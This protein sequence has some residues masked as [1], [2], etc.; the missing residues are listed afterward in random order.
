M[1]KP[2]FRAINVITKEWAYGVPIF[3]EKEPQSVYIIESRGEQVCNIET[4]GQKT[5]VNDRN[6]KEIWEGDIYT[7]TRFIN[8]KVK[9]FTGVI[10]F[11]YAQ[12]VI[13][14]FGKHPIAIEISTDGEVVGN[15]HETPD[16]ASK[17]LWRYE[18]AG[19]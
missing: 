4:L 5:G 17:S 2:L 1:R 13:M 6:G 7:C 11:K 3:K 10:T 12:F 15:I 18:R 19:N 8:Q 14:G 16:F 9:P